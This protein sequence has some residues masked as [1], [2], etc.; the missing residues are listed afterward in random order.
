MDTPYTT[1]KE[2][3][4]L[5]YEV[6]T[7]QIK[8][9]YT[10][11]LTHGQR[12]FEE[13]R[14]RATAAALVAYRVIKTTVFAY[15]TLVVLTIA[16][17][18]ALFAVLSSSLATAAALRH[19][20]LSHVPDNRVISLGFNTIPFTTETW[21]SRSLD[22]AIKPFLQLNAPSTSQ[23]SASASREEEARKLAVHT[24]TEPSLLETH[25]KDLKLSLIQT[26]VNSLLATTTMHLP[27]NTPSTLFLPGGTVNYESIFSLGP[28]MFNANG[29]YAAKVQLIFVKEKQWRDVSLVLET[30]MLFAEDEHTPQALGTLDVLFSTTRTVNIRTGEP[31]PWWPLA[32]VT[33]ALRLLWYLPVKAYEVVSRAMYETEHAPFPPFDSTREVAVVVDVYER[34]VPPTTLQPRL[35]AVNFTLYQHVEEGEPQAKVRL[36]RWSVFSTVKVRGLAHYLMEYPV[37]TF[38]ALVVAFFVAYSGFAV[39]GVVVLALLA[40]TKLYKPYVSDGGADSDFDVPAVFYSTTS[41]SGEAAQSSFVV[42]KDKFSPA[43]VDASQLNRSA[44]SLF[45]SIQSPTQPPTTVKK[46]Q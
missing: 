24:R 10:H 36:A 40:Y 3:A 21:R 16:L 38:L 18:I 27:T 28:P 2:S 32:L 30:V 11:V 20:V 44:S 37:I 25:V 43:T 22:E 39:V 45:Y 29:E 8:V 17:S 14:A 5:F 31:A 19:Y 9:Y 4:T 12:A 13:L 41:F 35:R 26:Y 7:D 15:I 6:A 1:A 34:F 23:P 33:V 42:P 46:T